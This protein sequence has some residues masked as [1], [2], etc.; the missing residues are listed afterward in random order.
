MPQ[1]RPLTR[2]E[3]II[4]VKII[5]NYGMDWEKMFESLPFAS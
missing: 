5:E 3:D 4:L 2:K 1:L